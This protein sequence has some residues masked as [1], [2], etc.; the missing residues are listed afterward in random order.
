MTMQALVLTDYRKLELQEVERPKIGPTDVLVRVA[1]C[2]ICGS[3]V[4]GYDGSSGRRMPPIIMG[5][6]AAGTISQVGSGVDHVKVGDRVTFDSTISCGNCD[7]CKGGKVNL[8]VRRRVL[9]VSCPDYRQQGAFAEFVA[10]PQHILY[11]LPGELPFE[12]AALIEPVSVAVH[13]VDRLQVSP[14][15][16]ALVVGS[17]M[18]GLLVIQMLRV[19]GC[20]DVMAIDLDDSRLKLAAELGASATINPKQTDAVCAVMELTGGDGADVAVEVVG[21]ALGLA[22]AIGCVRRGGSVGLIGNLA[23]EVPFPLQAVV[24]RELTLIGNCASAGEY[25]RA[26]ELVAS[27]AIRVAPLIN[28]VAPLTEGPQWFERLYARQ[29]GLMKIILRPD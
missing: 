9:G 22:T 11:R 27:G 10:V 15:S 23:P 4:H 7:A 8:C 5:H 26:L 12:Q 21:N 17:G 13:A 2:G 25:P 6:E 19:A 16:R 20:C 29:P 3:D 28:A 24:T 18:I 1:A 14:G